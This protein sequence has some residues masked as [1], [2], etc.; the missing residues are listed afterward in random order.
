MHFLI[1]FLSAIYVP[2]NICPWNTFYTFCS[3]KL[4]KSTSR[5]NKNKIVICVYLYVYVPLL[6]AHHISPFSYLSFSP[7][8][9]NFRVLRYIFLWHIFQK[10]TVLKNDRFSKCLPW[11]LWQKFIK[12]TCEEFIFNYVPG[13]KS[14]NLLKNKFFYGYISRILTRVSLKNGSLYGIKMMTFS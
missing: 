7:Y 2:P 8:K 5:G 6:K 1:L 11:N 13:G 10:L 9:L 4:G 12:S 14:E 3:L